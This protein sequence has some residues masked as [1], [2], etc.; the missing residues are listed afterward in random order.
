[1]KVHVSLLVKN[2]RVKLHEDSGISGFRTGSFVAWGPSHHDRKRDSFPVALTPTASPVGDKH[3]EPRR[4]GISPRFC[5]PLPPI[6]SPTACGA[7]PDTPHYSVLADVP[8]LVK[9]LYG[10]PAYDGTVK[11]IA[12]LREPA[13][14]TISS[15]QFK[16]DCEY[17]HRASC[18]L[19]LSNTEGCCPAAVFLTEQ[20]E[21]PC[22]CMHHFVFS[23]VDG[24]H[25]HPRPYLTALEHIVFLI[26]A[27]C[28]S[29][30]RLH[31]H[32]MVHLANVLRFST[33][34]L[35]LFPSIQ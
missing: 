17:I 1:M 12:F 28:H 13:A 10:K 4:I 20:W 2:G 19:H 18:S 23:C 14:R 29:L 3:G 32:R 33:V 5:A 24:L 35:Y 8:Y 27:R 34:H 15:W 21:V 6:T 16:Y 31:E 9:H 22:A 26:P 25:N 30:S 7:V 11:Y